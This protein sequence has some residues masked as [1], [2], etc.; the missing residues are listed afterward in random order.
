MSRPSR[1]YR[2]TM[3]NPYGPN[4][5]TIS[6]GTAFKAGFFGFFGVFLAS[7]ILAIFAGLILA[8]IAAFGISSIQGL[9]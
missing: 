3:T 4:R 1:P 9:S 6:A 5:V 7:L 8:V 2:L